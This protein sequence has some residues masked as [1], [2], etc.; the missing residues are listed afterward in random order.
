MSNRKIVSTAA[1]RRAHAIILIRAK[2]NS[3][4][5]PVYYIGNTRGNIVP[6]KEYSVKRAA[7]VFRDISRFLLSYCEDEIHLPSKG[8]FFFFFFGAIFFF[9]FLSIRI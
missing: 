7:L 6:V 5:I 4:Y 1:Y 8:V 2:S 9:A 3:A